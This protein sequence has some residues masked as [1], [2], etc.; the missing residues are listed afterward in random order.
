MVENVDK[1]PKKE[2][3]LLSSNEKN[4]RYCKS[5]IPSQ[6]SVCPR[7]GRYQNRFF[8]H[9]RID[10]IGLIIA[11]VLLFLAVFQFNQAKNECIKATKAWTKASHAEDMVSKLENL[12][13]QAQSIVEFNF[14]FTKANSDDR[15]AF[16]RLVEIAQES[17]PFQDLAKKAKTRIILLP[18]TLPQNTSLKNELKELGYT[19]LLKFYLESPSASSTSSSVL[20]AV[21]EGTRLTNEEEFDFLVTMID[22]DK[23][24]MVVKRACLYIKPLLE[25]FGQTK[26]GAYNRAINKCKVYGKAWE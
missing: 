17:G 26:P 15:G 23:S 19:D 1:D 2:Y 10:H 14:L 20:V 12:V 3:Q 4:C 22:K 13:K 8:N 7:C 16:D 9:F 18:E 6:A 11:V 21:Y 24:L 5:L 25:E